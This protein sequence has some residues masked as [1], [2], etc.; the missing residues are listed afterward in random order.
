MVADESVV[1]RNKLQLDAQ[2]WK[3]RIIQKL[4]K[5]EETQIAAKTLRE[6]LLLDATIAQTHLDFINTI[7][8]TFHKMFFCESDIISRN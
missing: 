4:V 2:S 7:A 8:G 1:H 3:E 6:Q 5:P